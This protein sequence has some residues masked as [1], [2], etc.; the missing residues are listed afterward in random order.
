M[1][2]FQTDGIGL[3]SIT[4]SVLKSDRLILDPLLFNKYL[5]DLFF[6]LEYTDICN[7][8]DDTTFHA[9]YKD[10]NYLIN[11]L[12][13]GSLTAIEWFENNSIDLNQDKCYLT[14]SVQKHENCIFLCWSANNLGH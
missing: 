7:F 2:T 13:H 11:R 5:N 8:A 14:A 12:K 1:A 4:N 9:C 6:L 3:K 10:L